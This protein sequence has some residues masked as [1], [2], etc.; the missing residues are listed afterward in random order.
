MTKR[1][2]KVPTWVTTRVDELC[3]EFIDMHDI[4]QATYRRQ[5]KALEEC[6]LMGAIK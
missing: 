5:R 4:R 1:V 2:E 6:V 3:E